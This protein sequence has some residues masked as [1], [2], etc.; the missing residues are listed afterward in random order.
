MTSHEQAL[1]DGIATGL[2][3]VGVFGFA[4]NSRVWPV[5]LGLIVLSVALPIL[6]RKLCKRSS[7]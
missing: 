4:I 5:L 2:G 1:V 6:S 7:Q 3:F